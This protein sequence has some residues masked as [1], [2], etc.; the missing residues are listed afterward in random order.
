MTNAPLSLDSKPAATSSDPSTSSPTKKTPT[1]RKKKAAATENGGHD[2]GKADAEGSPTKKRRIATPKRGKKVGGK[3]AGTAKSQD[4]EKARGAGWVAINA[5]DE[6]EDADGLEQNGSI[7]GDGN[8]RQE[9]GVGT[10][11]LVNTEFE[12]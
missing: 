6:M 7:F 9:D 11:A 3:G 1:P 4:G 10:G 5:K 8:V 2:A 12:F